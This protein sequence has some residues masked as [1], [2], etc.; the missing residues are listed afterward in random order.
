MCL[1]TLT[2]CYVPGRRG[3]H[4]LLT[5]TSPPYVPL[6]PLP[7]DASGTCTPTPSQLCL[8]AC[9]TSPRRFSTCTGRFRPETLHTRSCGHLSPRLP[10]ML[11]PRIAVLFACS[12]DFSPPSCRD[13]KRVAA[14]RMCPRATFRSSRCTPTDVIHTYA[15]SSLS[16]TLSSAPS[17]RPVPIAI[18]CLSG[19]LTATP[20]RRFLPACSMSPRRSSPCTDAP[21]L[22]SV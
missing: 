18:R 13:V 21:G 9:S 16:A 5:S 14:P 19:T 12:V 10:A 7:T 4:H 22:E 8:P 2:M 11:S 3:R 15:S 1:V 17:P 6:P 20:S